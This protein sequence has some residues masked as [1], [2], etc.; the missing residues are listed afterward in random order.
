MHLKAHNLCDKGV[1]VLHYS[2][3]TRTTNIEPKFSQVS[4][5]MH[6]LI[7]KVRR[8]VFENYQTC[9]M[10]L[11]VINRAVHRIWAY[12][13]RLMVYDVAAIITVYYAILVERVRA[14]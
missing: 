10:P 7:H 11:T 8:L 3:A 13:Y 2:L 9:T 12:I 4:C 14:Y 6:M 5:F 1:F